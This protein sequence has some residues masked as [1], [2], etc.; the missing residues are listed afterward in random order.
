M[1]LQLTEK[2]NPFSEMAIGH[3]KM[4]RMEDDANDKSSS[5]LFGLFCRKLHNCLNNLILYIALWIRLWE[6]KVINDFFL[7][8][9]RCV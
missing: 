9:H 6:Y 5:F 4:T 1:G 8:L 3:S 2:Q 7:L